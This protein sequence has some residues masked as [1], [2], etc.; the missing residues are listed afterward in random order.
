MIAMPT[1]TIAIDDVVV[2]EKAE[3]LFRT[4]ILSTEGY[5]ENSYETY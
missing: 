3:L 5:I 2:V 4:Y 1:W